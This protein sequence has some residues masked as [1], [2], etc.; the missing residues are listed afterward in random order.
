MAQIYPAD[1]PAPGPG[2][3]AERLIYEALRDGLPADWYVYHHV[4]YVETGA[5]AEGE[6]DFVVVHPAHGLLVVECKGEGVAYTAQVGWQRILDDG[7]RKRMTES[8]QEQA[9]R[10]V[11]ALVRVL[12]TRLPGVLPKLDRLPLVHGHCVALPMVR[13]GQ[14]VL[15]LDLPRE[16]LLDADDLTRMGTRIPE[17]LAFWRQA[18][19]P[20]PAGMTQDTFLRF[21]KH[22]LQ[23]ELRL[24]PTLGAQIAGE[25][26]TLCRLSSE[27]VTIMEGFHE[28][29]ALRVVG[30]AGTGKTM[31]ALEAARHLATRG[32]EVLLLC[33]NSALGRHLARCV[34][35]LQVA[36]GHIHAISFHRLCRDAALALGRSWDVPAEEAEQQAFWRE[37]APLVLWEAIDQGVVGPWDALVV[38]EAQDFAEGWWTALQHGLRS[39]PTTRRVAFADPAQALFTQSGLSH[40]GTMPDWPV[41]RLTRNYRNTRCIAEV[42]ARLGDGTPLPSEHAPQGEPPEIHALPAPGKLR[43]QLDDLIEKLVK[44][45]GVEP[46]RITLLT[47]HRRSNSSLAAV[48]EL[49][50]VPLVDRPEQRDQGLLHMTIGAFKGL[51]SDVIVLADVRTDDPRCSRA[52]RYVAASRARHRLHVFADGDWLA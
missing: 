50:G 45:E 41:Y 9:Q 44:R 18:A 28:M 35:D 10:T 42:V 16:L 48:T 23:P 31:L 7:T 17:I 5:A 3:R 52:V 29:P 51:E 8:P 25:A 34:E 13:A 40:A 6:A 38:D 32:G 39:R 2:R 30:G 37:E 33:F 24:V 19:H 20:Q 11:K 36:P 46:A 12:E 22:V 26:A 47:P 4:P 43:R 49:G 1:P 15:P 21:R 27:Q 14:A